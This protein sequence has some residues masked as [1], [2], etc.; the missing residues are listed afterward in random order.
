MEQEQQTQTTSANPVGEKAKTADHKHWPMIAVAVIITAIVAGG[1]TYFALMQKMVKDRAAVATSVRSEAQSEIA[2]AQS[3]VEALQKEMD[4]QKNDDLKQKEATTTYGVYRSFNLGIEFTRAMPSKTLVYEKGDKINILWLRSDKYQAA[5]CHEDKGCYSIMG[6]TYDDGSQ[7]ITVF[8]KSSDETIEEAIKKLITR[9]GKNP[10]DCKVV[11]K[12]YKEKKWVHMELA[13]PYE[14][15]K[16]ELNT[17]NMDG[18]GSA[19]AKERIIEGKIREKCY[20]H[21]PSANFTGSYN[22]SF[23]YDPKNSITKFARFESRCC[24]GVDFD[25]DS[26]RFSKDNE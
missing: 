1:G 7:E 10:D 24:D 4:D 17:F 14:P 20:F 22:H 26:I 5:P 12:D 19:S 8:S 23:I 18:P 6:N 11:V 9:E 16:E 25:F 13:E 15:S 2:Q 21:T 3:Q